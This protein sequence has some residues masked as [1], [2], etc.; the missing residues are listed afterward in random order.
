MIVAEYLLLVLLA[1]VSYI[2]YREKNRQ[3]YTSKDIYGK[4]MAGYACWLVILFLRATSEGELS[5]QCS[6]VIE[7]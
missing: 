1:L 3:F 5:E 7:C 6:S 4:L 2:T